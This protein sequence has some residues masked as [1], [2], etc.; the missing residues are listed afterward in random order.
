MDLE[1]IRLKIEELTESDL[2][3]IHSKNSIME[4]AEFNTIGIPG[5]IKDT[6]AIV[7][8]I[9]V[10][11]YNPERIKYGWAIRIKESN[12]FIGEIGINLAAARFK[13]GEIYYGFLPE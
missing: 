13:K 5:D 7:R 6:E 11:K 9:L 12:E 8:P 1:T 4:V 10:D 2:P 3:D